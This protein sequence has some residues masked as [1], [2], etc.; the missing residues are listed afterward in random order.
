M[1]RDAEKKYV[2]YVHKLISDYSPSDKPSSSE[3]GFGMKVSTM[4]IGY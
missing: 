2:E 4:Q 3:S 1:N